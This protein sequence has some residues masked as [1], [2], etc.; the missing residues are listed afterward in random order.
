[1]ATHASGSPFRCVSVVGEGARATNALECGRSII[2]NAEP[3]DR[4]RSENWTSSTPKVESHKSGVSGHFNCGN[5]RLPDRRPPPRASSTHYMAQPNASMSSA[6]TP[7]K[8]PSFHRDRETREMVRPR[9]TTPTPP[10]FGIVPSAT[11]AAPRVATVTVA[12]IRVYPRVASWDFVRNAKAGVVARDACVW[13]DKQCT[14]EPATF[15]TYPASAN[16]PSPF[17]CSTTRTLRSL[18]LAHARTSTPPGDERAR[19]RRGGLRG[20]SLRVRPLRRRQ[21]QVRQGL[22]LV[23]FSAQLERFAWDR[24]CA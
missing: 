3:T 17:A 19:R 1:M 24:G 8:R 10:H 14:I 13:S 18:T 21:H 22:T 16:L 23:H 7:T 12:G 20:H 4:R 2:L 11:C 5:K 15:V 6:R 9:N